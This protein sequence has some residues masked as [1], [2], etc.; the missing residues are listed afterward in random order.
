MS[1]PS[2]E[3]KERQM[4]PS[5]ISFRRCSPKTHLDF[6][7]ALPHPR[8]EMSP[9]GSCFAPRRGRPALGL[10]DEGG[11]EGG[12]ESLPEGRRQ[13]TAVAKGA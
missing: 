10:Y 7:R 3:I 12:R 5:M 11:W 2:D 8:A 13:M 6:W 1:S 4:C 9:K